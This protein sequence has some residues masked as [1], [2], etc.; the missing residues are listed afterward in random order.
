MQLIKP[1]FQFYFGE[2]KAVTQYQPDLTWRSFNWR[3]VTSW[4]NFSI[5]VFLFVLYSTARHGGA[6][7]GAIMS[8]IWAI[9]EKLPATGNLNAENS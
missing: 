3:H 4:H 5:L 9:F 2:I 1:F 8:L 6:V 7:G